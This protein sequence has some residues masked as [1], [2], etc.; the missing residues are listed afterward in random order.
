M[1]APVFST[2]ERKSVLPKYPDNFPVIINLSLPDLLRVLS[3][4]GYRL[5][6]T[7][8]YCPA[9]V[10]PGL[11]DCFRTLVRFKINRD[12]RPKTVGQGSDFEILI[13]GIDGLL[14]PKQDNCSQKRI[15]YTFFAFRDRRK[16][17][18]SFAFKDYC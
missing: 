12:F 10:T 11:I 16:N 14:F 6:V 5:K 7:L 1:T 17:K 18:T 13:T 15:A 4:L 2:F 9:Q 3:Q 8:P